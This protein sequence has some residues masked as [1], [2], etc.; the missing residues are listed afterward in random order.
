MYV[1]SKVS[2]TAAPLGEVCICR[3]PI[4]MS[5]YYANTHGHSGMYIVYN[6][7]VA[8]V[9]SSFW[10]IEAFLS[11]PLLLFCYA[12]HSG[13]EG[14][15]NSVLNWMKNLTNEGQNTKNYG[16]IN[17][18]TGLKVDYQQIITYKSTK[19]SESNLL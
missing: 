14:G 16:W 6:V 12:V 9:G 3:N 4:I 19:L 11:S 17:T 2:M 18:K 10:L 15:N 5:F 7:C 8:V 13:Q 1:Y